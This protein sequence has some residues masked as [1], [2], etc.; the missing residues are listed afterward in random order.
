VR[1]VLN[2]NGDLLPRRRGVLAT[3]DQVNLSLD[4]P[5]GAAD[6]ARGPG[7]V[8]ATLA[9]AEIVHEAGTPL[10]FTC[11]VRAQGEAE[12]A[13]IARQAARLGATAQFQT[14]VRGNASAPATL[15][16]A[17]ATVRRL[18]RAGA[19][20][21]QSPESLARLG[22][23]RPGR[24]LVCHAMRVT[25]FVGPT[26]EVAACSQRWFEGER[27]PF[28]VSTAGFLR[29]FRALRAPETCERCTCAAA[30]E[31]CLALRGDLHAL[32]HLLGRATRRGGRA[33]PRTAPTRS[34]VP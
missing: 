16:A 25:A 13:W 12:I 4:G 32:G 33:R 31:T 29:A 26:P 23:A 1:V 8:D 19:P 5:P 34:A 18:Q 27:R 9:A 17:F 15:R 28:P 30:L 3:V 2:T 10:V 21:P 20:F 6:A 24:P 7:A 14:D 11:V 22:G